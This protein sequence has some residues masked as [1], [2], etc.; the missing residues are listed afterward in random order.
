M[1]YVF[2]MYFERFR[3]A[4]CQNKNWESPSL[5]NCGTLCKW[6]Y[7]MSNM[8]RPFKPYHVMDPRVSHC[9]KMLWVMSLTVLYLPLCG[10]VNFC[11]RGEVLVL[12]DWMLVEVCKPI[13]KR[14]KGSSLWKHWS[15]L[16][17]IL[18]D[19]FLYIIVQYCMF[20]CSVAQR[21]TLPLWYISYGFITTF[22]IVV[23][24]RFISTGFFWRRLSCLHQIMFHVKYSQSS[25]LFE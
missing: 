5:V 22:S 21:D 18:F 15:W 23:D 8:K 24:V 11:I 10:R 25:S 3:S 13:R 6:F 2:S 7:F 20:L 12:W 14:K 16:K 4:K 17:L 19:L 9:F 1:R